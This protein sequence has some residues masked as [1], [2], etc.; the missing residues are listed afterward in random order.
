VGGDTARKLGPEDRL[1]GAIKCCARG[2]ITPA[3]I[4]AGAGAALYAHLKEKQYS[5]TRETAETVLS[6]V[7]GLDRESE[8][9]MRIL[10]FYTMI[11]EGADFKDIIA[12]AVK[13]GNKQNV[14]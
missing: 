2:G 9:A 13:I 3:F 14:I 8:E 6:E 12:L 11:C 10:L 7:S 5:Q 4:S 1:I